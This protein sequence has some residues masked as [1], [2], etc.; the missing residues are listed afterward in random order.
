MIPRGWGVTVSLGV[1]L[2]SPSE[3]W[4]AAVQPLPVAWG[5]WTVSQ[6]NSRLP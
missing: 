1:P 2:I 4:D 6:G 5:G 3:A